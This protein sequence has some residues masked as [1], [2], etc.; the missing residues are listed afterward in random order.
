MKNPNHT[1]G[2][3]ISNGYY[4]VAPNASAPDEKN[5]LD[6]LSYE[7]AQFGGLLICES[8]MKPEDGKLIAAAPPLAEALIDQAKETAFK[9]KMALGWGVTTSYSYAEEAW[10]KFLTKKARKAL[11]AAGYLNYG[12]NE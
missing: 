10:E 7:N 6:R 1:P 2:P 4:V 3:W 11:T 12:S 9:N 5:G 8:V